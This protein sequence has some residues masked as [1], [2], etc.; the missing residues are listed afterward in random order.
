[1]RMKRIQIGMM[2]SALLLLMACTEKEAVLPEA[3]TL[4]FRIETRAEGGEGTQKVRL[5]VADRRP[6]LDIFINPLCLYC[7]PEWQM[8]LTAPDASGKTSYSLSNLLAQWYKFAF[9]CVPQEVVYTANGNDGFSLDFTQQ[10]LDYSPVLS[11]SNQTD[12]KDR[13]I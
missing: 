1:M 4:D 7:P 13:S 9:V 11:Q 12:V 6:E 8:D 10:W 5:Y 3:G 2:L